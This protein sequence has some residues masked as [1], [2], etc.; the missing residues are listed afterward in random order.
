MKKI[1]FSFIIVGSITASCIIVKANNHGSLDRNYSYHEPI[2]ETKNFE[3]QNFSGIK[4]S[5]AIKVEII[6]SDTEKAVVTSKYMRY[7]KL[8]VIDGVLN[9]YYNNNIKDLKLS[10]TNT[11]II[12]YAKKLESLEASSA[13]L[14]KVP[15][16]F[17]S[18]NLQI[19]LSSSGKI[20]GDFISKSVNIDANSDGRFDGNINTEN[21]KGTASSAGQIVLKGK[22]KYAKLEANSSGEIDGED[23]EAQEI[24]AVA[25]STGYISVTVDKKITAYASSKGKIRYQPLRNIDIIATTNK[26][27]GGSINAFQP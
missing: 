8:E 7:L 1:F 13:G 27:S 9:V 12:V 23:F 6:K 16:A 4:V 22:T 2:P 20:S 19:T 25:S 24:A 5:Q 11:K 17:S 26:T 18:N 3:V 15:S 14:I 21:L 10:N